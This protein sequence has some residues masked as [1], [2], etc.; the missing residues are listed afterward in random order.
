VQKSVGLAAY[1]FCTVYHVCVCTGNRGSEQDREGEREREKQMNRERQKGKETERF[2]GEIHSPNGREG[3]KR[4]REAGPSWI[5]H[6][7]RAKEQV[8]NALNTMTITVT[9]EIVCN[10]LLE[11]H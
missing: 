1:P 4:E 3:K 2:F 11:I 7:N 9:Y 5:P 6:N 10:F 8:L